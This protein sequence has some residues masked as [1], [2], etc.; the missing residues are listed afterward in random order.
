[1]FHFQNKNVRSLVFLICIFVALDLGVLGLN[2]LLS[3]SIEKYT[4]EINLAGRQRMLT[5]AIAKS[6]HQW[7]EAFGVHPVDANK[8]KESLLAR[9][10]LFSDTLEAFKSGGYVRGTQGKDVEIRRIENSEQVAIVSE[11]ESLWRGW[12]QHL[13][14]ALSLATDTGDDIRFLGE[15]IAQ[16][17]VVTTDLPTVLSE[18]ENY[19]NQNNERLLFLMD[20]LTTTLETHAQNNVRLIR[21]YQLVTFLLVLLNFAFIIRQFFSH[22]ALSK[23]S[24]KVLESIVHSVNASIVITNTSDVIV[25]VNRTAENYFGKKED[26]LQ[27]IELQSLVKECKQDCFEIESGEGSSRYA[28]TYYQNI[29][30][31]EQVYVICTIS[32]ITD[33]IQTEKTLSRLAYQDQLTGL[34]N[35][36]MTEDRLE[37]QIEQA[38]RYSEVFALLYL[39]LDGFKEI[40]DSFGHDKGDALLVEVGKALKKEVRSSDTIGRLGGDEFLLICPNMSTKE[41]ASALS[42]K[43]LM[44]IASINV[45]NTDFTSVSASI[46]IAFF[47]DDASD[48]HKLR[49]LADR[50]M[51]E[52]KNNGKNQFCFAA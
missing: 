37:Q 48:S 25:N 30:I 15:G 46:G 20:K 2:L 11:A 41:E 13:Y 31:N 52:A 45:T 23:Q 38:R 43:I 8:S 17:A 4:Q 12:R 51:Y 47:P 34:A 7:V 3:R 35:R 1:M 10:R 21:I 42:L 24:Q 18:L 22:L 50:A 33:Q 26:A 14:T 9:A 28:Q 19:T 5:Q 49:Q 6:A 32:D 36:K 39:D 40:N 44:S 16:T 29:Q 27:G